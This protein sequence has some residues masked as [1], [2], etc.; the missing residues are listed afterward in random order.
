MKLLT[1]IGARPQF[2]KAAQLSKVF[3]KKGIQEV[4]V[5]TGQHFDANMSEVFFSRLGLAQPQYQLGIHSMGHGAMTGRMMEALEQIMLQEK[6]A[7]VL[8]YGDTNSTLAGALAAAKLHIPIAHVEAGLRS[9]NDRM[10]EELNRVLTDRLSTWLFC[11]TEKAK[12][13]LLQEGISTDKIFTVGDIMYDA[14]LNRPAPD[15]HTLSSLKLPEKFVLATLHRQENLG[16]DQLLKDWF[17]ALEILNE[18]I[19]V[20]MPLHPHTEKRLKEI[21]YSPR[22]S[23]IPPQPYAEMMEL[24][25]KSEAVFTDSGGL[26]K[27]A[28]YLGKACFTLREET[29]WTELLDLGVNVLVQKPADLISSWEKGLSRAWPSAQPYG[30]GNTAQQ[31]AAIL[32]E[33]LA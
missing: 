22:F 5:H 18:S 28:F 11:P 16:Q 15:I 8:V 17:Q 23:C 24:V 27:E 20:V 33:S 1:V 7:A 6:P 2:I 21:K 32:S 12:D 31:I 30:S 19:S 29:E 4:L 13:N 14:L 9:Y 25:A 10:P 26:Q 3:S